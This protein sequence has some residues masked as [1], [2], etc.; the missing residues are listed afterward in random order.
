M[1]SSSSAC[2]KIEIRKDYQINSGTISKDR[3]TFEPIIEII[4]III[5]SVGLV[6]W[7]MLNKANV[8][9]ILVPAYSCY[10]IWIATFLLALYDSSAVGKFAQDKREIF[11]GL[12]VRI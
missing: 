3:Y 12:A 11:V 1:F 8:S 7:R 4:G 6:S 10:G 2:T 9:L 5:L